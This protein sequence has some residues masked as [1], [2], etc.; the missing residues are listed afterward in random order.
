MVGQA[1]VNSSLASRTRTH[2]AL[3]VTSAYCGFPVMHRATSTSPSIAEAVEE[4]LKKPISSENGGHYQI[5]G[6]LSY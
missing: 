5:G 4:L 3:P 6:P 2:G 1:G